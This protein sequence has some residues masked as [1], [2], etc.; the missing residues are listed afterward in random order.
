MTVCLCS[1]NVLIFENTQFQGDLI[2]LGKSPRTI[3]DIYH[4]HR[5]ALRLAAD[6]RA[7]GASASGLV[8]SRDANAL[9]E[10][11]ELGVGSA[12]TTLRDGPP[13]ASPRSSL[14]GALSNVLLAVLGAG[15]LTLPWALSRLGLAFGLALLFVRAR[16]GVLLRASPRSNPRDGRGDVWRGPRARHRPA[17]EARA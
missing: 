7:R 4:Y 14:V 17:V 2:A 5:I 11:A 8:S 3:M 9:G 15:Q 6:G 16:R 12:D 10:E 1:R 13:G